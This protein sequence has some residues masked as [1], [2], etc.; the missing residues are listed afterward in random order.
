MLYWI[1]VW[2]HMHECTKTD[3]EKRAVMEFIS[4][5]ETQIDLVISQSKKELDKKN[6]LNRIQGLKEKK[7]IDA[8][9]I[10]DAIKIIN[11]NGHSSSSDRIGGKTKKETKSEMHTKENTEVV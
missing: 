8:E 4:F 1:Q 3:I 5:F 2:R 7:R 10:K 6:E 11:N 9:C